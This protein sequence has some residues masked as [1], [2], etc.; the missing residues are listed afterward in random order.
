MSAGICIMNKNAIALAADSAVTVG[1]HLAIH[2]SANKLFALSKVAPVGV[3][4]YSNAE[5]MGIPMEIIIKQYKSTLGNSCFP[6]LADY[7]NDFLT[8]LTTKSMLFHF[9]SNETTYVQSLYTDLL[10]GLNGDYELS[11]RRKI[12][13]VQ[14]DLSESELKEIQIS[15]VKGTLSFIDRLPSI[16]NL[17]LCDY[18]KRTYD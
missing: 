10:A 12:Q 9:S 3:I 5:L 11:V 8:F 14:R 13:E 1:Q 16:P 6:T 2:N 7:V 4:I 17:N 15:T 18:I